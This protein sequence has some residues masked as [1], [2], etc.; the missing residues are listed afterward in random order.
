M[1]EALKAAH[2]VGI[3]VLGLGLAAVWVLDLIG[4]RARSLGK[5]ATAARRVALA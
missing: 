3:V 2:I 5:I 4:R 1:Y